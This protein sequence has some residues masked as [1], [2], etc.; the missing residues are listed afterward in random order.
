MH[1]EPGIVEGAKI[2]L[3]V[4]TATASIGLLL[5][6]AWKNIKRN[7]TF[8][9]VIK[10]LIA[11]LAVF[12]FFE[13]LPHYPVGV[14]EVHLILGSTLYL[15]LG[16]APAAVGLSLGLLS[17]GILFAPFDL[18]QFG[19][20]VTTLLVPLFIMARLADNVIPKDIPYVDVKYSQALR[21]SLTYQAGIVC[22]VAF[23]A[24]YGQGFGAQ[25]LANVARFGFAYMGVII[26]EPLAD[27]AIL[28]IAKTFSGMQNTG[29]VTKRLY[30]IS[31]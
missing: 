31:K 6:E 17:Q 21:L 15:V 12:C 13:M 22:W 16:L 24:F 25:N 18:P 10:S 26:I 20:N 27:L 11:T 30:Q 7:D 3:S 5:K 14:S 2:F 28:A 1:I 29:F 8:T 9:F 23:W 19:M 4:A